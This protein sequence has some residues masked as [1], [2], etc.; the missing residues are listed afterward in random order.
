MPGIVCFGEPLPGDSPPFVAKG[1]SQ[2][3]ARLER[4][5]RANP[6]ANKRFQPT[7][8]IRQQTGVRALSPPNKQLGEGDPEIVYFK[9]LR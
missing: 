7:V 4:I 9:Q 6:C 2:A 1:M 8:L 5:L 3:K